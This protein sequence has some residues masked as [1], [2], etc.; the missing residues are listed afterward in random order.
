M[1]KV[2]RQRHPQTLQFFFEREELGNSNTGRTHGKQ[3]LDRNKL[4]SL[5]ALVFAEFPLESSKE[6]EKIGG[7]LKPRLI[8]SIRLASY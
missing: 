7:V 3:C 4:N 5:Q 6:K 8:P 1:L 2:E